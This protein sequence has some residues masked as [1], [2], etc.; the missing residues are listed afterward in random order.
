MKMVK[1]LAAIVLAGV[2]ALTVLTGCGDSVSTTSIAGA[3][4]DMGKAGGVTFKSDSKLDA[5]AKEIAVALKASNPGTAALAD[6]QEDKPEEK[7]DSMET[8]IMNIMGDSYKDQFVWLSVT[9]TKGYNTTAQAYNLLDSM[10]P[11]NEPESAVPAATWYIGT[12]TATYDG[13]TYRVAVITAAAEEVKKPE[14][15]GVGDAEQGAEG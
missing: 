7:E 8:V 2:M 12:T 1:K 11:V 13:T 15:P 6:V 4:S 9:E 10:E 3:L 5:K 14:K